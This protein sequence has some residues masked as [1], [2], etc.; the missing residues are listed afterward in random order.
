[1]PLI[2]AGSSG[3][4]DDPSGDGLASRSTNNNGDDASVELAAERDASE[5]SASD[6]LDARGAAVHSTVTGDGVASPVRL[7][8][9]KAART[10]PMSAAVIR[11]GRMGGIRSRRWHA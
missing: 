2:H 8:M 1:M 5:V 9:A 11:I 7:A 3:G 10:A 4:A 6:V